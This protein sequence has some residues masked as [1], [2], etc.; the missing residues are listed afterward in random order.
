MAGLVSHRSIN[1]QRRPLSL[2]A[3]GA[4]GKSLG[5]SRYGNR[6]VEK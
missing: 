3:I 1:L 4:S 5:G 6:K 2:I